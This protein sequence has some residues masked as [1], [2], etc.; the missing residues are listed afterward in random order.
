MKTV[1]KVAENEQARL[2][3]SKLRVGDVT[4]GL[5]MLSSLLFI[6]S[7]RLDSIIDGKELPT[8]DEVDKIN[9]LLT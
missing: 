3:I 1:L 7:E 9:I 5:E 4:L 8:D 2:A 6:D